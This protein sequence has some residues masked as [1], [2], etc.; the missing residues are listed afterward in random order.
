[1]RLHESVMIDCSDINGSV[2]NNFFVNIPVG[3]Q[4]QDY[5]S[6]SY[7]HPT[8]LTTNTH[9]LIFRTS[10]NISDST[11]R[12]CRLDTLILYETGTNKELKRIV[13]HYAVTPNTN[14]ERI[15]STP[16]TNPT[17]HGERLNNNQLT[18]VVLLSR[19]E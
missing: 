12:N 7:A 8:T 16:G 18:L 13:F 15:P 4:Q 3:G 9:Y 19:M 11:D 10:S 17:W 5:A 14:S 6:Y 1:M 2:L